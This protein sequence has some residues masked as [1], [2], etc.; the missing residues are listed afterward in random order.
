M[1]IDVG[2]ATERW[3]LRLFLHRAMFQDGVEGQIWPCLCLAEGNGMQY[4]LRNVT[5][6]DRDSTD[7]VKVASLLC[8]K[9]EPKSVGTWRCN[10]P[11]A[12]ISKRTPLVSVNGSRRKP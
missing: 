7:P 6:V 5:N 8:E 1:R 2:G 12:N 4:D 3:R 9:R 10:S 11:Y